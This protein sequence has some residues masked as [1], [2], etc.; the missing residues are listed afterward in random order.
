MTTEAP[1]KLSPA[2]RASLRKV[3]D[4]TASE[5]DWRRVVM[6]YMADH[7]WCA[8]AEERGRGRQG[9][10]MTVTLGAK[11]FPDVTAVRGPRLVVAELKVPGGT[12]TDGQTIWLN[13]MAAVPG[14]ETYVWYPRDWDTVRA[15]LR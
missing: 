11:G 7:D 10:W 15:T 9:G 2:V 13:R 1:R 4:G 6:A 14:V 3:K 5:T 8:H 12:L